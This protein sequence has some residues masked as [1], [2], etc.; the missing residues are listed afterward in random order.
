[1]VL[2]RLAIRAIAY[3]QGH[4]QSARISGALLKYR[5]PA[6]PH[7]RL[8]NCSESVAASFA[9]M[10]QTRTRQYPSVGRV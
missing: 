9:D 6:V 8:L 4:C 10:V 5:C 7:L 3:T 1:M 2:L